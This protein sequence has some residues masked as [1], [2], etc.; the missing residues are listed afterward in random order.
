MPAD[1]LFYH[2]IKS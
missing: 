1:N 2:S